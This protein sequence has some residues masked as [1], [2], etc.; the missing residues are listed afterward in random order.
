MDNVNTYRIEAAAA[1]AL[2]EWK[3]LFADQVAENAKKLAAQSGTSTTIT[4]RHYQKAA[5]DALQVL[6]TAVEDT[7]SNDGR[8]KAA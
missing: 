7:D 1:R 3:A 8:Q 2:V 4:L 5:S 6:A